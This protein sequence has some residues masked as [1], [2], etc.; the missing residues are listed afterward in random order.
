MDLGCGYGAVGVAAGAAN[1][2][3]VV[4]SDVN[5][6]AIETAKKNLENNGVRGEVVESDGFARI[7]GTFDYILTNPPIRAGKQVVYRLFSESAARL[8]AGGALYIVI[9]KQQ[10]AQSAVAFLGTL[11][12]S[13]RAADKTGGFWVLE[14]RHE[15]EEKL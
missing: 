12:A 13:V 15:G 7:E 11:F 4:L 8:N 9:R 1:D 10:G 3:R 2:I 5:A 6:R 14:C